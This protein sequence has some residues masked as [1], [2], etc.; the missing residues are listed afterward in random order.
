VAALFLIIPGIIVLIEYTFVPYIVALRGEKKISAL[1]YSEGLVK[2]QW[3]R[4]F[5]FSVILGIIGIIL[6][7][8]IIILMPLFKLNIPTNY[9]VFISNDFILSFSIVATTILFLNCDYLS[10]NKIVDD[11]TTPAAIDPT[12]SVEGLESIHYNQRKP[13]YP[14]KNQGS[15]ERDDEY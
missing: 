6:N 14:L 4:I 10:S 15:A 11:N 8:V 13:I 5:G 2:G 1:N 9:Y 7:V 12:S 3:S